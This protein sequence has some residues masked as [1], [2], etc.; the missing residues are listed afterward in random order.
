MSSYLNSHSS[1]AGNPG[2]RNAL[3]F[4]AALLLIIALLPLFLFNTVAALLCFKAPL[5]RQTWI[6]ISAQPVR[7]LRW[8]AGIFK[9]SAAVLNVLSGTIHFVGNPLVRA[10]VSIPGTARLCSPCHRPGLFDSLWLY[11]LIGLSTEKPLVLLHQ[12]CRQSAFADTLLIVRIALCLGLYHKSAVM[13]PHSTLFGIPF[14]NTRMHSAVDWVVHDSAHQACRSAYYINANSVNLSARNAQLYQVL[15]SSDRNFIDGSGMRIAARQAGMSL[16][17]NNNGTD[18]LPVLCRAAITHKRSLF[19]LGAQPGVAQQ[20]AT[21]LRQQFPGLHIA[22]V[23]HGYFDD[24][25]AVVN[26]INQSGAD[27]VLVALGSP[28]QEIWIDTNK[29]KLQAQCALAVGGLFDFFSGNIARAPMWMRELGL[30]WIWRLILEPKAKFN[31]YVLGNPIFL[32]RVYVLQ[33]ALRG[34]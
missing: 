4:C 25:E 3:R 26:Q 34:L 20:A 22:G 9:G 33:Q 27:I 24:D 30:E 10:G 11:S 21:N 13:P 8:Q 14:S 19:L 12:Q 31:R 5:T 18:M 29:H 2:V 7:L 16:A 1:Q 23:Q 28:R 32:F 6:D 15:R 17:D